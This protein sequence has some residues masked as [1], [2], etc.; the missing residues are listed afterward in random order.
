[1]MI[2]TYYHVISEV[3]N[4]KKNRKK[5]ERDDDD[6]NDDDLWPL[7]RPVWPTFENLQHTAPT[8]HP[9]AADIHYLRVQ[10]AYI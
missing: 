10:K 3:E 7:S 8:L 2:C 5:V 4:D 9:P 1:M 6:D